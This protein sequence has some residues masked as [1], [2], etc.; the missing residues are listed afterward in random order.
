MAVA[1]VTTPVTAFVAG[2]EQNSDFKAEQALAPINM[3][4]ARRHREVSGW[5]KTFILKLYPRGKRLS[6]CP[7]AWARRREP[8]ESDV[9]GLRGLFLSCDETRK[10]SANFHSDILPRK[11]S[12]AGLN[13]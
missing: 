10:G 6:S 8:S 5:A 9:P 12:G 11:S 4:V 7:A 2:D 13:L 1:G 3:Q